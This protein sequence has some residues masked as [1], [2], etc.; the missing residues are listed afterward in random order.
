MVVRVQ[1]VRAVDGCSTGRRTPLVLPLQI[2]RQQLKL[3]A[4]CIKVWLLCDTAAST[5]YVCVSGAI[6]IV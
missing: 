4:L 1:V 6:N 3:A 2:V 5:P